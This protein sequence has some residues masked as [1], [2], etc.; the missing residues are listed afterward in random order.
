M[1]KDIKD[2]YHSFRSVDP[3]T[4]EPVINIYKDG[5]MLMRVKCHREQLFDDQL[6]ELFEY[7]EDMSKNSPFIIPEIPH[8]ENYRVGDDEL[9]MYSDDFDKLIIYLEK[10]KMI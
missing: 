6:S 8:M 1:N 9:I 4:Y 10:F 2:R 7:I 5:M 3:L